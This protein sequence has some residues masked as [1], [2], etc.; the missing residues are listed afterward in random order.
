[1][2]ANLYLYIVLR[3]NA[4][5]I[6]GFGWGHDNQASVD[7]V[8]AVASPGSRS[9]VLQTRFTR[10]T[11]SQANRQAGGVKYAQT[12]KRLKLG[13]M[14]QRSILLWADPQLTSVVHFA[15]RIAK[16]LEAQTSCV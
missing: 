6:N 1:M 10:F 14:S 5:A 13:K 15:T 16:L 11:C 8:G 2:S 4:K 3:G 12:L 7:V 9:T